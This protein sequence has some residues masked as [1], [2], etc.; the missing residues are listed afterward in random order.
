MTT[1]HIPPE[2]WVDKYGDSF[3]RYAVKRLQNPED[4]EEV[5]QDTFLAGMTHHTAYLA[6]S[7]GLAW[8]ITTLR[9]KI[10]DRIRQRQLA[11]SSEAASR[12]EIEATLFDQRGRWRS[13]ARL[14]AATSNE[15]WRELEGLVKRCLEKIPRIQADVFIL[16][17]MEGMKTDQICAEL[18]IT[19][20]NLFVRLHRARLSLAQ[21][22]SS[23]WPT[24][25]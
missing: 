12:S 3:Y 8:L 15:E 18:G 16:W 5:V 22:V 17:V 7:S 24:E 21:C 1:S 20:D 4:A 25:K 10:V 9:R 13:S 19:G 6:A 23:G 14:T 11:S 2:D